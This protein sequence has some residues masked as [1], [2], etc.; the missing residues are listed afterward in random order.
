MALQRALELS[1]PLVNFSELSGKGMM[2]LLR[3]GNPEVVAQAL[4]QPL[5]DQDQTQ[6]T[7]LVRTVRSWIANNCAWDVTA[8]QLG[9]HRHTLRN[10]VDTAGTVLGL[11][12]DSL[13]DRLELFAALEFMETQEGPPAP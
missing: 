13:R 5:I 12:L 3:R 10:R 8:R 6:Q 2:G 11:N 1:R 4:L 7:E 9:I